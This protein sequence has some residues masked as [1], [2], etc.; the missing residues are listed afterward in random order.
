MH[1]AYIE[2]LKLQG[3]ASCFARRLQS[4]SK[5]DCCQ[6]VVYGH[7]GSSSYKELAARQTSLSM[8]RSIVCGLKSDL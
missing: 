2:I 4:R 7:D 8:G 6:N 1:D 3:K 5:A